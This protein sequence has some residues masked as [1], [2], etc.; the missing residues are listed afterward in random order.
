VRIGESTWP[1]QKP[2]WGR[3]IASN[4]AIGDV[5]WQIALGITEQ[6]QESKQRTGRPALAGPIVTP[7]AC[8]SWL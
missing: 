2:P 6:L 3:M 8:C 7:A 1:C 4:T 5:A